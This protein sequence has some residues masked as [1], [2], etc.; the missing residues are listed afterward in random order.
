METIAEQATKNVDRTE[1]DVLVSLKQKET[2]YSSLEQRLARFRLACQDLIFV[3]F[4]AAAQKK[5]ESRLWDAHSKVNKKFRQFLAQFREGDGKKNHVERRKAEKLYLE[6]IKSSMRFYR[7]YI[8]RLASHFTDIPEVFKIAR[9]F[10]LD[11]KFVV[12][13][14]GK[15]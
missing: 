12:W 11:S 7:G 4:A 1:K 5:T 14:V 13:K 9:K 15:D 10:N 6:F 2:A 3:D 8:Q